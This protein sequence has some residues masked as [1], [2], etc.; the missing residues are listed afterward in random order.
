[1]TGHVQGFFAPWIIAAAVVISHLLLPAR[2]VTGYARNE[3]TGAPLT[4]RLNGIL[5]FCT[6]IVIWLALGHYKLLPFDWLWEQR[7]SSALGA[8]ALGLIATVSAVSSGPRRHSSTL[9]EFWLGRLANP[10]FF[11]NRVDAKMILYLIGAVMLELNLLA[12]A[13][14]HITHFADSP[15]PGVALYVLL[16]TWFIVD[17]LFFEE[18]HLYTYD[19]FAERLG[20]KLVWGCLVFYPYFYMVGLWA[21]ADLPNPHSDTGLL[22]LSVLVFFS[23]WVLARGANM[24]KHRFKVAPDKKFLGWLKPRTVTDGSR[25]LLCSGF[26]GVAR[27]INYLGEV[28]MAVGLTLALGYPWLILPWLY[29]LYYIIFLATRERDDDKRCAVKYGALWDEYRAAVPWRIIP[30]VY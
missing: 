22:L 16:F 8:C 23:G 21:V 9:A 5:V 18:V 25:S 26:W 14:H 11:G 27:H 20:F 19:L 2:T 29:P 30:R 4:Y 13:M 15:S 3:Q 1:M 17:Y 6:F 24:Q 28:L 7:W 12:F 10:Q